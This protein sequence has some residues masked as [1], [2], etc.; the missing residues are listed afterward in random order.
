LLLNITGIETNQK[1]KNFE[2]K[3]HI[4]EILPFIRENVDLSL[5]V[6]QRSENIEE[7]LY[8]ACDIHI[9]LRIINGSLFLQLLSTYSPLYEMI[10]DT[11][12][13]Y[14]KIKLEP[15]V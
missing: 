11:S 13:G 1:V 14:P 15:I 10:N 8:D 12:S 7:S 3:D 4:Q 9:R 6:T 2:K 5:F